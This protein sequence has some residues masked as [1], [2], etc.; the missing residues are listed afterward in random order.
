M[1]LFL[2]QVAYTQEAWQSLIGNPQNR[3][4]AIRPAV[5][6]L[7]GKII[8][9]YFAFGDY[10]IVA[11]TEMPDNVAAAAI[12]IAFAAGGA[13]KSVKTTPLMTTAEGID[14]LKKAGASGY[15]PVKVTARAAGGR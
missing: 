2:T 5:E 6:K 1:P 10:D 14:A 4:D 3:I 13:C 7:G 11:I 8:S 9:G 15:K 12:A